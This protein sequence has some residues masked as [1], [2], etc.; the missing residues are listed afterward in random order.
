[1]QGLTALGSLLV[2]SVSAE[3]A[4]QPP[5]K[6][7]LV[8]Y[9]ERADLSVIRAIEQNIRQVF[10]V[11]SWPEIESFSEDCGFAYSPLCSRTIYFRT[12]CR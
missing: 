6:S 5:L 3:A 11:S 8:T 12:L 7:V 9:G 4:S 2:S 10:H 1:M